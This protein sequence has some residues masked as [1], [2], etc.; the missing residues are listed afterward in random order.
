VTRNLAESQLYTSLAAPTHPLFA[1]SPMV[2]SQVPWGCS[3]EIWIRDRRQRSRAKSKKGRES[4]EP[5]GQSRDLQGMTDLVFPRS[6]H[7][8]SQTEFWREKRDRSLWVRQLRLTFVCLYTTEQHVSTHQALRAIN[9]L[10]CADWL[11]FVSA[12]QKQNTVNPRNGL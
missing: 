7:C 2:N 3:G 12:G 1:A 11:C 4:P 9:R 10:R 6:S 5:R 8:Y